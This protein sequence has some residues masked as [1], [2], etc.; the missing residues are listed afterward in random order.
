MGYVYKKHDIRF[1]QTFLI[2]NKKTF[3]IFS[4]NFSSVYHNEDETFENMF[5]NSLFV[6]DDPDAC[7]IISWENYESN[8]H[9][10]VDTTQTSS[11]T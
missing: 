2:D 1:A 10:K 11:S 4:Q 3:S 8:S 9:N 6:C 7:I 5:V